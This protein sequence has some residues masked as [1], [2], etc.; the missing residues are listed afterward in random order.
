MVTINQVKKQP[1]TENYWMSVLLYFAS[2]LVGLG[3]VAEVAAN[4]Q[5]ISNGVKLGGALVLMALNSGLIWWCLQKEFHVLKK[6][7]CCI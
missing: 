3:L 1:H 2:F 6:V 7:L 5:D 4:W